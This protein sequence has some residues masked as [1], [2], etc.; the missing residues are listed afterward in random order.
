MT[1]KQILE[2]LFE[3]ETL[4]KSEAK[5]LLVDISREKYDQV[6]V[7]AF[8]SVFKMRSITVDELDGFRAALLELC[9]PLDV[10]GQETIDV[11]GTGGDGKSTFNISTLSAF[12]VAGAGYKVTKHGNYGVSSNCGSS[13]VLESLGYEFSADP[14]RLKAE[15]DKYNICFMHAPKFHPALKSL[16]QVR[17]E[18]GVKTFFNILGPLVNPVQPTHQ[19]VGVYDLKTTRL[20]Q[21]LLERHKKKFTV[22]H[23]LDGYDEISLT[24]KARVVTNRGIEIV[25]PADFGFKELRQSDIFGGETVKD[26][27]Q[28]FVNVLSGES[29]LAQKQ[30]V[31]AN[32][33]LGI[34]TFKP[35]ISLDEAVDEARESLESGKAYNILKALSQN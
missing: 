1:L 19:M 3:Y 4:S 7:A 28:I 14:I 9:I 23:A 30:V 35:N 34:Q 6:Q 15:L 22:V 18:L 11:C 21:Y 29:S 17:R 26:S 10:E 2:K 33:A 16:G 24:C 27:A 32:A 20:Y 25:K 8:L 12:V 5:R 13:N 31:L